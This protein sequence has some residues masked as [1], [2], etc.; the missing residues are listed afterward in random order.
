MRKLTRESIRMNMRFGLGWGALSWAVAFLF[1]VGFDIVGAVSLDESSL[2]DI[3][4]SEEGSV[5]MVF[6]FVGALGFID[7]LICSIILL[8]I[9]N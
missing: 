2:K 8:F 3:L 9:K 4:L 1:L 5:S 6:L 7:S